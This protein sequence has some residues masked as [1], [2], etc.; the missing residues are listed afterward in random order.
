LKRPVN[1]SVSF[2]VL[3]SKI[4][5]VSFYRRNLPHIQKDYRPHFI[6]FVT[7]H[8]LILPD[9]ARDIVLGCCNHGHETKYNLYAA[10]VMPDHVHLIL[11]PL[12]DLKSSSMFALHEIMRSIKSHSARRINARLGCGTLWQ[13]ESFD[14]VLRSSESLDAKIAYIMANPVRKGLVNVPEDYLWLWRK[15]VQR[16]DGGGPGG[17]PLHVDVN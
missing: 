4:L 16:I 6:T 10:V 7:K 15:P 12:L 17:P 2:L 1:F 13:Q 9:W 5:A 8:R 14:R 11:T 3:R